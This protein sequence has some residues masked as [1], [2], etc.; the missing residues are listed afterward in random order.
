MSQAEHWLSSEYLLSQLKERPEG[1]SE[2]ALIKQLHQDGH[3]KLEADSFRDLVKLFRMH[4]LLFHRLYLLRDELHAQGCGSLSV[5]ALSI[6]LLPYAAS[7]QGLVTDDPL[8]RYYLDLQNLENDASESMLESMLAGF[9]SA[10]KPP[11]DESAQQQAL[12]L[13]ELDANASDREIKQAWRRLAMRHHPDRGG[14]DE[15][16][17]QLNQ[18]VSLLL[19]GR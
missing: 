6:R 5:Q 10:L 18:A 9:W 8:R 11:A 12:Q 13:L 15:T 16:I 2:H 19:P 17:K 4:F 7:Q 14:D 3:I 1:I